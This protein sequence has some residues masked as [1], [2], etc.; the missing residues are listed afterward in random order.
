MIRQSDKYRLGLIISTE[1]AV[2]FLQII[3]PEISDAGTYTC[4]AENVVGSD[5][6]SAILTVNGKIYI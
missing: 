6:S 1:R 5:N 4:Y 3:N 2:L